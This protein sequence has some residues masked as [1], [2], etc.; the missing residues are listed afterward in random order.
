MTPPFVDEIIERL[1]DVGFVVKV[2]YPYVIVSLKSRTISA[3]EVA[4][5][6]DIEPAL[7][8]YNMHGDVRITCD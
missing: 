6:L 8:T 2:V 3:M 1:E 5:A 4:E 7:V